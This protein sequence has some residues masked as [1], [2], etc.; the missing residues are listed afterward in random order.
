MRNLYAQRDKLEKA[1]QRDFD[2]DWDGL[3]RLIHLG[4]AAV[5]EEG[6]SVVIVQTTKKA[7]ELVFWLAAGKLDECMGLRDQIL[8]RAREIG[9]TRAH[10][11]C[12]R[13]WDK[14]LRR[15]GWK[16]VASHYT[17]EIG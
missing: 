12:R 8:E 5:W 11:I 3:L 7:N 14:A 6:E 17:K 16:H 9:I 13:G 2:C 4:Q 1:L 10:T 15:D